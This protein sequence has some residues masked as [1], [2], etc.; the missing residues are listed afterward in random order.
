MINAELSRSWALAT[1]NTADILRM[2]LEAQ[3][4]AEGLAQEEAA[5]NKKETFAAIFQ[6]HMQALRSKLR[7]LSGDLVTGWQ[8]R[9]DVLAKIN[10]ALAGNYKYRLTAGDVLDAAKR[11]LGKA[12][13]LTEVVD[14]LIMAGSGEPF[15][16]RWSNFPELHERYLHLAKT[17]DPGQRMLFGQKLLLK[18]RKEYADEKF[19]GFWTSEVGIGSTAGDINQMG[20]GGKHATFRDVLSRKKRVAYERK[21][22]ARI[23]DVAPTVPKF[24]AMAGWAAGLDEPSPEAARAYAGRSRSLGSLET[25]QLL[26][27]GLQWDRYSTASLQY[28]GAQARLIG[29]MRKG[30]RLRS[31]QL[32]HEKR[33]ALEAYTGTHQAL[34]SQ[35]TAGELAFVR[36]REKYVRRVNAIVTTIAGVIAGIAVAG[37][38]AATMG[39]ALPA[40][41]AWLA[42]TAIAAGGALLT[43]AATQISHW[44]AE[45]EVHNHLDAAREMAVN[46]LSET[47]TATWKNALNLFTAGGLNAI[48][49]GGSIIKAFL[50]AAGAQV[51]ALNKEA[52]LRFFTSSD[53]GSV[54]EGVRANLLGG[55]LSK[56]AIV[57]KDAVVGVVSTGASPFFKDVKLGLGQA[58]QSSLTVAAPKTQTIS[59]ATEAGVTAGLTG[60]A[61]PALTGGL[62][63]TKAYLKREEKSGS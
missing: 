36:V 20:T 58:I 15:L 45:G 48:G 62:E 35:L 6:R 60:A 53:G 43:Q 8:L 42:G 59:E 33:Q 10:V 18:I 21:L 34:E 52:V 31:G 24:R 41:I 25:G 51:T 26:A 16:A 30:P 19:G 50:Q 23:A 27:S 46:V 12:R 28:K 3:D 22:L 2:L 40:G 47:L 44:I 4:G 9:K 11:V 1:Q 17:N 37:L 13:T 29:H 14:R 57:L 32:P 5:K 56:A 38:G 61:T 7:G 49:A 55:T 54:W 63:V 39:G